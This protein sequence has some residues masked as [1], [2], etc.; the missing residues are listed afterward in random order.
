MKKTKGMTL[1]MMLSRD[2]YELPV[3]VADSSKELSM[4]TGYSVNTILSS[5]SHGYKRFCKVEVEDD[6]DAT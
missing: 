6:N 5:I 3:A 4:M 1:Y 2:E